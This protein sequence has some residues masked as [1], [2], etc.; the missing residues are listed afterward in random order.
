MEEG[1]LGLPGGDVG[2]VLGLVL[3][4]GRKRLSGDARRRN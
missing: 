1:A 3:R 2:G 4:L